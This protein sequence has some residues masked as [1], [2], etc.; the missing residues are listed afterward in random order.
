M[1]LLMPEWRQQACAA[2]VVAYSPLESGDQDVYIKAQAPPVSCAS[3]RAA[4]L[5]PIGR[6]ILLSPFYRP[7]S[8]RLVHGHLIFLAG[9][10]SFCTT[11]LLPIQLALCYRLV[12]H[13]EDD[14]L[15]NCLRARSCYPS[16]GRTKRKQ[17]RWME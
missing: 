17:W 9:T 10:S 6:I 7:C 4:R 15:V 13:H 14:Q 11:S 3:L 1:G 2:V 5:A 16:L 12:H 8:I